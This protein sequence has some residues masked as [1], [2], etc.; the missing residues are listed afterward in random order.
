MNESDVSVFTALY[1]GA[2]KKCFGHGLTTSLSEAESKVFA[3][4]IFDQTGLVIGSKSIKNYSIFILNGSEA[5]EENPSTATL[6]TLARYVTGAPYT[7]E[8]ERKSKENHYPYW[9]RYKDEF[10]RLQKKPVKRKRLVPLLIIAS[11]VLVIISIIIFQLRGIKM[12]SFA[13]DFIS[14]ANDTLAAHGWFVKSKDE[15]YWNKRGK[16]PGHLTLYTLRGEN[17]PDSL[18]KPDIKNLLLRK[19]SADCFIVE[20]HLSEFV[21][22]QNWQQAGILLLEDTNFAGKS[23]R[24]SFQYNDFYGGFPK[25]KD[26]NIQAIATGGKDFDKPEVLSGLPVY[27]LDSTN[28]TLVQQNLRHLALRIEKHDSKFRLLYSNGSMAN[29]AF[30]E[31]ISR[32]VDIEPRYLALFALKGHIDSADNIPARFD[33]FSYHPLQCER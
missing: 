20:A 10:Y 17:W 21:P 12:E 18:N 25:S 1:K 30:K 32:D 22:R 11:A 6:D 14:V 29:A 31:I 13:D 15:E 7:S 3:N 4:K 16:Y 28:E 27:K 26:I 2:Y 23:L 24:L 5:K 33:F 19:I 9:F 8:T